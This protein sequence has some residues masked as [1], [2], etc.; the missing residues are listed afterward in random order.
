LADTSPLLTLGLKG[1][2]LQGTRSSQRTRGFDNRFGLDGKFSQREGLMGFTEM[3]SEDLEFL[4]SVVGSDRVSTGASILD[5]HS[6]DE[7]YHKGYRPSVV[8]WPKSTEEVVA[9]LKMANERMLPVT[10]WGAGT[11]LE[12]NPLPVE[13][14]MVLDFEH[15]DQ[16]LAIRAE[17]FQVDVQPGVK[18]KD[19]NRVLAR[20]GLFFAPDPGANATIGGM[21]ANNASGIRTVKYGSTRDNVLKLKIVLATGQDFHAGSHSHKTSSGYDLVRLMVG[22]EG[23]LGILTE[24]T[25][26]LAGIPEKFSAAVVTFESVQNAT[27]A[28]YEIMGSG[29]IPAALEL[30]DAETIGAIN[31]DGKVKLPERPT[32]FLEF[33]GSSQV[34]LEEDL[35][36]ATEICRDNGAVGVQSGVGRE[37]RN[38][39]WEARHDAYESL[40]HS[41]PGLD[42]LIAD[43]AVPL[44]KYSNMVE[45]ARQVVASYGLRAYAFGHA[46][47]GNLHLTI[48]GDM[49]DEAFVKR[50]SQAND[51]IVSYAISLGGTATGEHGIGIGKRRFTIQ[52]HGDGVEVMRRIKNLLDP[53]GIL[54]PGKILP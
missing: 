53:N 40:K 17:D 25:L 49:G 54:N 13:G 47:D 38:R 10:P 37:E 16:I 12:G 44:S 19:M 18:Y 42:L 1:S 45:H 29:L 31:R 8:V 24:I 20:H 21:V 41:N 14:G 22:S 46:G 48:V 34:S 36:L 52:E 27:D 33:T 9:I 30:L 2:I 15:M 39:L 51:E 11:S 6:R 28:V 7:S 50:I 26:R 3:G 5:L 43:T 23:T 4:K 32:L 35:K